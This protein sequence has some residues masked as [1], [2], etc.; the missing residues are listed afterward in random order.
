MERERKRKREGGRKSE[1]GIPG[2]SSH[3]ETNPVGSG[4][5]PYDCL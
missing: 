5:H 3:N 2:A 4:P 1:P